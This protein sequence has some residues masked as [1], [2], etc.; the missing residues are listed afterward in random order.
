MTA[1][2]LW[3]LVAS[4]KNSY[5]T[6]NAELT[7]MAANTLLLDRVLAHYGPEAQPFRNNL[8]TAISRLVAQV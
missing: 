6:R 1:L 8:R 7:Q 5:G 3:L 4:A 2:L